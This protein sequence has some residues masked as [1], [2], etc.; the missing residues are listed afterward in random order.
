MP[1]KKRQ[2]IMTRYFWNIIDICRE[3]AKQEKAWAINPINDSP[4]FKRAHIENLLLEAAMAHQ[5]KKMIEGLGG[6]FEGDGEKRKEEE[7]QRE[8]DKEEKQKMK[9]KRRWRRENGR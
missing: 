1:R 8:K 4:S 7:G 5:K 2:Q 6:G 9:M 3:E